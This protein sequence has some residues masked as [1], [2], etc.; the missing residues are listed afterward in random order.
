MKHRLVYVA[1]TITT[2]AILVVVITAAFSAGLFLAPY[3]NAEAQAAQVETGPAVQVQQADVIAAYEDALAELYDASI[4]SVVNIN[5][6]ARRG[7][8]IPEHFGIPGAPDESPEFRRGQGSGFVWDDEG[9]IVTNNHVVAGAET[10]EVVFFDETTVRAEVLGTDPNADLAVLRVER[11]PED[12]APLPRSDNRNLRVGQMVMA[13]GNP[14]GQ[15]FTMTSGIISAVGRT[16]QGGVTG[17]SIPEAIQTD[18]AINPGNSGGPLIDSRGRVIGINTMMLS[19]TGASSG[20]GFAVPIQIAEQVVPVLI[21]GEAF[22]Y[23][24]LGI[25][26]TTLSPEIADAMDLTENT[27]GIVVIDVVRD[28]PAAKA[29]LAGS[30]D[31][32]EVAGRQLPLGGDIITAINGEPLNDMDDLVGYL[33]R[34]TKPGDEVELQVVT[35]AGQEETI[36]VT[37]GARPGLEELAGEVEEE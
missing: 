10:V 2:V 31:R 13:M 6:T 16:I 20:I 21:Q 23:A 34:E 1:A 3:M 27:R 36:T 12:A 29:G 7:G 9:H 15:Q 24:W 28:G 14:F 17:F 4:P 35:A 26:G 11:M 33:L 8:Q 32:L 22:Q 30:E 25:S 19:R 18:A 37:L 5:V